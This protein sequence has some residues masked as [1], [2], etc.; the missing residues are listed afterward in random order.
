M[1]GED[2]VVTYYADSHYG[3]TKFYLDAVQIGR[4]SCR[5]RVL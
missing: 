3:L 4:V 1:F 2:V 5:E